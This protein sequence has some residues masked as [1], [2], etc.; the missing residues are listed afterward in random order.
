[1]MIL[2][3]I[4]R[5]QMIT[6]TEVKAA[7]GMMTRMRKMKKMVIATTMKKSNHRI[8]AINHA[9]YA[10]DQVPDVDWTSCIAG[11]LGQTHFPILLC[12][13]CT[14]ARIVSWTMTGGPANT[15]A[16]DAEAAAHTHRKDAA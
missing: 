5:T 10:Y 12:K 3:M 6:M 7:T 1:M 14:P 2:R 13:E 8:L 9:Q 16:A 11:C 15:N 4:R